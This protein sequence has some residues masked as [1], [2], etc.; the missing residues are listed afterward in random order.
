MIYQ[1]FWEE[2]GYDDQFSDLDFSSQ[3]I[4]EIEAI[5]N[6]EANKIKDSDYSDIEI[7]SQELMEIDGF[8]TA[9]Y[10]NVSHAQTPRKTSSQGN[11]FSKEKE[12]VNPYIK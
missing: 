3:E 11:M 12:F 1:S 9:T 6:K 4:S 7:T 10:Q 2:R 5:L 8:G